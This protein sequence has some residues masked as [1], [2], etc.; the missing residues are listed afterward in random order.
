MEQIINSLKKKT[1]KKL[2][3]PSMYRR[4]SFLFFVLVLRKSHFNLQQLKKKELWQT[5][6]GDDD[7]D[8]DDAWWWCEREREREREKDKIS[9]K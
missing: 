2:T 3:Y 9:I 5:N 4:E 6:I 7:D 1:H 8:D